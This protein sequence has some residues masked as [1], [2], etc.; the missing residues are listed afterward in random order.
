MF[1]GIVRS[2]PE[3]FL[4]KPNTNC[5]VRENDFEKIISEC[6]KKYKILKL[7]DLDQYFDGT[8]TEDGVLI[9][10]D[11]GLQSL[12]TLGLPVL[13]KYGATATV[14]ITSDWTGK[15]IQPAI[16][17]LEY[18]LYQHLPAT[19]KISA[20]EFLCEVK[21]GTKENIPAALDRIWTALFDK[22][23][24]PLSVTGQQISINGSL[25][26]ELAPEPGGGN[27]K[28]VSWNILKEAYDS[29]II[30]IGAHGQ[31]HT[32]FSWLA[33]QELTNELMNNKKQILDNLQVDATSCSFPHGMADDH[34]LAVL[35]QFFTY[36]FKNNAVVSAG[37]SEKL[38][39]IRYNVPFQRPNN[40]S[41]L[42]E[43]PFLGKVLRKA[44]SVTGLF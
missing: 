5:F 1:H 26:D 27:W 18:Q 23:I 7:A 35:S 31:T 20:D 30:E 15:E 3:H 13:K 25:L 39:I 40:L 37:K 24:S 11:D 33:G 19:V 2:K 29:G 4:Y 14:F 32:P 42:I 10:F 28:T 12:Y 16:F 34:S 17:S 8:A 44:G 22:K 9:S 43:Y 41:S 21:A 36:G 38:N 6:C